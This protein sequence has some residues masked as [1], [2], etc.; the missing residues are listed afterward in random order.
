MLEQIAAGVTLRHAEPSTPSEAGHDRVMEEI[1]AGALKLRH[2]EP[3]SSGNGAAAGS[4]ARPT[5]TTAWQAKDVLLSE[6]KSSSANLIPVAE[7]E[8]KRKGD[9][10]RQHAHT[11]EAALSAALNAAVERQPKEPLSFLAEH[12]A[13]RA[14]GVDAAADAP[15]KHVG[16]WE[17]SLSALAAQ[18]AGKDCSSGGLWEVRS[19]GVLEGLVATA[20]VQGSSLDTGR[21]T[22]DA[23]IPLGYAHALCELGSRESLLAHL[24]QSDLLERVSDVMWDAL[25]RLKSGDGSDDGGGG[26][27]GVGVDVSAT[28]SSRASSGHLNKESSR[29]ASARSQSEVGVK[30]GSVRVSA[31]VPDFLP[32]SQSG[33]KPAATSLPGVAEDATVALPRQVRIPQ[34]RSVPEGA[35]APRTPLSGTPSPVAAPSSLSRSLSSGSLRERRDQGASRAT[36]GATSSHPSPSN[37]AALARA[38]AA[39]SS[40][41]SSVSNPALPMAS[42]STPQATHASPDPHESPPERRQSSSPNTSDDAGLAVDE[43]ISG[44]LDDSDADAD[45]HAQQP[46]Q[47]TPP[48][49][50]PRRTAGGS[51]CYSTGGMSLANTPLMSRASMQAGARRPTQGPF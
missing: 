24:Q 25:H 11:M 29:S 36:D 31:R 7:R 44:A 4:G 10:M 18:R 22:A 51:S 48:I 9:F 39:R 20:L 21:S 15:V 28:S 17:G 12:L 43:F 38:R 2:V 14:A 46:L 13:N 50:P 3:A 35:G 5:P 45:E 8:L 23:R 30:R 34:R 16:V 40:L 42:P 49:P 26:G 37:A 1:A 32:P 27:G 6:L 41:R 33:A 47:V 19:A